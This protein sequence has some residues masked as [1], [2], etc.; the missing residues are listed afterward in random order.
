MPGSL[1]ARKKKA[2]RSAKRSRRSYA[3]SVRRSVIKTMTN[4]QVYYFDR[5]KGQLAYFNGSDVTP[6]AGWVQN[7]ALN[8]L[9]NYT[10]FTS[11]FDQF[12]ICKVYYRFVLRRSPSDITTAANKGLLTSVVWVHD[13]DGGSGT[14][15][16]ADELYQYGKR[17]R[18]IWLS[19]SKPCSKW[20]C[21]KPARLAQ[22]YESG[23][24][25]AY[26]PM[27]KGY[28]NCGDNATPHYGLVGFNI[29]NYAGQELDIEAK[30][31][32]AMKNVR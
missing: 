6:N 32:L 16:S 25:A 26:R 24:A 12:K 20:F 23:V 13:F 1:N 2:Q 18:Q 27:W 22:E 19:D 9:P 21:I 10:E 4:R 14:P 8:Q 5:W 29:S 28:V 7:F 3:R 31:C 11:L 17:C 15:T 30:Y